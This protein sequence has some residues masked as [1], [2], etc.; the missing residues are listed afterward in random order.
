MAFNNSDFTNRSEDE[1]K[2]LK[3]ERRMRMFQSSVPTDNPIDVSDEKIKAVDIPVTLIDVN[4]D[5]EKILN[6][7]KVDMLT[8]A[9]KED[10]FHGVIEVI[11]K[12]NGRYEILSGHQRYFGACAARLETVP[13]VISECKDDAEKAMLLLRLNFLG[14]DYTPLDYARSIQY[15]KDKVQKFMKISGRKRDDVAQFFDIS[16]TT[17][18][19]YSTILKLIPELQSLTEIEDFPWTT[20]ILAADMTKDM[21]KQVYEKIM[22]FHEGNSESGSKISIPSKT[23]KLIIERV[24]KNETIEKREDDELSKKYIDNKIYNLKNSFSKFDVNMVRDKEQTLVYLNEL[25]QMIS[26]LRKKLK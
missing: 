6:M 5:N 7:N 26:D 11:K 2:R 3:E 12:D 1:R 25:E 20:L 23:L 19:R 8:E 14:R 22:E 10:G 24:K 18:Q 13:C 4:P 9:I 15:Y 21:Q 17:V 16:A